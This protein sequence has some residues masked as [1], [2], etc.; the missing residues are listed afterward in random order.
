MFLINNDQ[1]FLHP[2]LLHQPRSRL[3][4]NTNHM[5]SKSE[6]DP[7]EVFFLIYLQAGASRPSFD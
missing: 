4:N 5:T 7:R 1:G 2:H 6:R 3:H